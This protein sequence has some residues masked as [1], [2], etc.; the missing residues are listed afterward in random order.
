MLSSMNHLLAII[1]SLILCLATPG[2]AIN[3]THET[4]RIEQLEAKGVTVVKLL[5][6]GAY[7]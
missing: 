7:H 5:H 1:T 6:E 3:N 2:W 4:I